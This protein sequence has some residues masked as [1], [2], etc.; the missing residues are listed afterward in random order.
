MRALATLYYD[1]YQLI[2]RDNSGIREM[3]DIVGHRIAIPPEASGQNRSF[4][5]LVDHY[6]LSADDLVALP[7]SDEAAN[8]AMHQ[9]QVIFQCLDQ[10]RLD[11]VF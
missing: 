1:A 5:F 11:C 10:I 9:G 6:G 2:V 8:F 7:I 4:W 3:E